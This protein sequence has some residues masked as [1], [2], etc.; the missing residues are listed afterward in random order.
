MTTATVNSFILGLYENEMRRVM[1]EVVD[2]MVERF[3]I[4]KGEALKTIEHK[5]DFEMKPAPSSETFKVVRKKKREKKAPVERFQCCAM[6]NKKQQC[7]R[8][9]EE[10]QDVCKLHAVVKG[11]HG[12]VDDE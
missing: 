11:K 6:T 10:G 3:H 1:G 7:S 12:M 8:Y 4:D 2:A 9:A 5:L